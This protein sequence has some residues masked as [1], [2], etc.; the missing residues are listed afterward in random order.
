MPI[1]YRY[2]NGN[3][4]VI[5]ADSYKFINASDCYTGAFLGIT[6]YRAVQQWNGTYRDV[7]NHTPERTY[8]PS[9]GAITDYELRVAGTFT[10]NN[11][12]PLKVVFLEIRLFSASYPNGTAWMRIGAD[13]GNGIYFPESEFNAGN[14]SI[15]IIGFGSQT[16]AQCNNCRLVAYK[17]GVS[18]FNQAFPTCP[19]V[20]VAGDQCPLDTCEVFCGNTVCCYNS[21][22]VSIYSFSIF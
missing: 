11:G 2:S 15:D 13:S 7:P 16:K 5:D 8:F 21:E 9:I 1:L 19:E 4:N 14:Y 18:V 22:G 10:L 20:R 6:I 17:Q 3:W 12:Y